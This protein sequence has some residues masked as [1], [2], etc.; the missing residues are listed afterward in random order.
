MCINALAGCGKTYTL[1]QL[2]ELNECD[3][4]NILYLVFNK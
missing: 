3:R 1:L 4:L 2:A